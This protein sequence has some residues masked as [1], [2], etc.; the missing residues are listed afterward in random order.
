VNWNDGS[1]MLGC[2]LYSYENV[3]VL[4]PGTFDPRQFE[5]N[6]YLHENVL[7]LS[8]G[9]FDPDNLY[10]IFA[11]MKTCWYWVRGCSIPDNLYVIFAYMKTCWYWVRRWSILG[12]FVWY[13]LTSKRV[14]I[15]F[16]DVRSPTI[17]VSILSSEILNPRQIFC[18]ISNL[19]NMNDLFF[20][21]RS[22]GL[23]L[24]KCKSN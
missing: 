3:L 4:S 13:V 5:C 16:G 11:Y 12:N 18:L 6:I 14:G 20:T 10:V 7:I 23:K 24:D 21:I 8:P 17:C 9:M 15:E 2:C 19:Y 22:H 1:C